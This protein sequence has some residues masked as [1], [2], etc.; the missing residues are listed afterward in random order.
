MGWG[1]TCRCRNKLNARCGGLEFRKPRGQNDVLV[2]TRS[3]HITECISIDFPAS[4]MQRRYL[5]PQ[6]KTS[7]KKYV[8][9]WWI[10]YNFDTLARPAPAPSI[11]RTRMTCCPRNSSPGLSDLNSRTYPGSIQTYRSCMS[12]VT[13]EATHPTAR[14]HVGNI[15]SDALGRVPDGRVLEST[16]VDQQTLGSVSVIKSKLLRRD[17]VVD[18]TCQLHPAPSKPRTGQRDLQ[19]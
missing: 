16:E 10:S 2:H 12:V 3:F 17:L 4:F 14:L 13:Q 7:W 15:L 19:F 9:A 5:N 18:S 11:Q 6:G 8:H 1:K